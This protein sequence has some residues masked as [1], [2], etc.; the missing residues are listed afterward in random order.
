MSNEIKSQ[1][2]CNYLSPKEVTEKINTLT[3]GFVNTYKKN[4][5]TSLVYSSTGYKKNVKH[6]LAVWHDGSFEQMKEVE[7]FKQNL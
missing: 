6:N 7:F 3:K 1:V 2:I 4:P 5:V